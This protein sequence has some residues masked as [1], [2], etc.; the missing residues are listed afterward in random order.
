MDLELPK[1][2]KEFLRLLR[3][4]GVEYLLIG[5]WAVGYHGYPRATDDLDVWIAIAPGNATRAVETLIDFGF[6][7]PELSVNLFLQDDQ[8]IRMGV[9]PLRIEVSTSISGVEFD[10]CYRERLETTLDGEPVSLI[11][12]NNLRL[13]KKASGRLKDLTDLEH[14]P[15]SSS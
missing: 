1:D 5:G 3:V 12:L 14:L 6:D 7:V 15:Q 9:A 11:S 10:E 4:H 2:F 8:I 13:N